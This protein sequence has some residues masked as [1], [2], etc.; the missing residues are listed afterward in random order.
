M[1]LFHHRLSNLPP[2]INVISVKGFLEQQ[3]TM[4]YLSGLRGLCHKIVIKLLTKLIGLR[5]KKIQK[6]VPIIKYIEVY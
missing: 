1:W 2:W 4:F 6:Q 3:I 5:T